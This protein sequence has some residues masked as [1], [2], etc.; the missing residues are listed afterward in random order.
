LCTYASIFIS[1][2]KGEKKKK[3]K[4]MNRIEKRKEGKEKEKKIEIRALQENGIKHY[5]IHFQC[6]IGKKGSIRIDQVSSPPGKRFICTVQIL[7]RDGSYAQWICRR[8]L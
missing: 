8:A 6:N 4:R 7:V 3:R 1:T 5:N 2:G